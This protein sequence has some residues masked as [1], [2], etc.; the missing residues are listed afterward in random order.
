MQQ[1]L[2]PLRATSLP[3]LTTIPSLTSCR[4]C[5]V[6]PVRNEAEHLPSVL[7]ALAQQVDSHGRP[8]DSDSYEV[9]LFANNCTDHSAAIARSVSRAYPH[10]N[11]HTIEA[12]LP[13]ADACIGRAR[14]II[15]DEAF[16]RLSL[17]NG[18]FLPGTLDKRR[19][20][21]STDGDTEVS[22]TWL[23]SMLNEFERGVDVVCGRIFTRRSKAL[24]TNAKT[25]LY[26]LRYMA[27]R[28][29]TAQL[30]GYLDP[31]PH[32]RSPRHYQHFGANLALSTEIYNLVGGVPQVR[33]QEDVAL[34][35]QLQRVDAKIRHSPQVRVITSARRTGRASGGLAER[36]NYLSEASR[37][38][39]Q[40]L[41]ESP[42]LTEARILAYG[43][44]RQAWGVLNSTID[45]ETAVQNRK[46]ISRLA[47]KLG[48]SE[49]HLWEELNAAPTF[50]LLI[51]AV[52]SYQKQQINVNEYE[53]TE[54][55]L[56][57]MH[58]RQRLQD[59]SQGRDASDAPYFDLKTLEQV[60]P[61]PLFSLTY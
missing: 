24:G 33:Q 18:C 43:Q 26:F 53:T 29:L 25:S 44:L 48:F 12:T 40:I 58:L 5:V 47:K 11:L 19:F 57:N 9:L 17:I 35:Q 10:F 36:L 32:D 16:R 37:Y 45:F 6:I 4:I 51:E 28:Y 56:A 8:I 61:I 23:S 13:A 3:P 59:L 49:S 41:V 20:I 14:Q 27:H 30:E 39:Q 22:A 52:A 2:V 38:D 60:Q 1:A 46:Q 34:Y 54:I 7:R 50:G 31:Q 15:M 42:Y 55:S 21:A